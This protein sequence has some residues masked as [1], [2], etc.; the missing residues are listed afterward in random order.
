MSLILLL[1]LW[2]LFFA[3]ALACTDWAVLPQALPI[4]AQTGEV[5]AWGE[6]L[7]LSGD[8]LQL[9]A[10]SPDGG[11]NY[12]SGLPLPAGAANGMLMVDGNLAYAAGEAELLVARLSLA[13]A[14]Q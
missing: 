9:W 5:A 1:L 13:Q 12:S 8:S 6:Q 2:S 3:P 4:E 14:P 10:P 7:V 11:F